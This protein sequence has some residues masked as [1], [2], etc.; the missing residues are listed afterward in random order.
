MDD[1]DDIAGRVSARFR[2]WKNQNLENA[3][4]DGLAVAYA[5]GVYEAAPAGS[6][7]EWVPAVVGRCPDCDDNALEPTVRGQCFPT[8]QPFPPAHPGCRCLLM[9]AA[10]SPLVG[11]DA[12][13][14]ADR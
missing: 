9:V 12:G 8:G 3:L 5:R 11:V 13:R 1:D 2:E 4:G 7:L 10:S 14:S 6:L